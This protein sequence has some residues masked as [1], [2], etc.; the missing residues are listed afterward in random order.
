MPMPPDVTEES[1]PCPGCGAAAEPEQDG[2]VTYY[3]CA[4]CGHEFSHQVRRADELLCA[5]GLPIVASAAQPAGVMTLKSGDSRGHVFL[6]P[7][8]GR[9]PE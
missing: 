6:G 3:A 2:Q 1:A 7:T 8:I 4:E 5:A 9:R